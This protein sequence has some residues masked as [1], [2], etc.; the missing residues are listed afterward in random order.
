MFVYRAFS[1]LSPYKLVNV[2][3]IIDLVYC[4]VR[5][6][7]QN[8]VA[9]KQQSLCYALRVCRSRI[10][11][12]AGGVAGL[13]SLMFKASAGRAPELV[14]TRRLDWN[15]PRASSLT[16]LT[17]GASCWLGPQL[18]LS[19]G[20]LHAAFPCG[21]GYL[22]ARWLGS[23]SKSPKRPGRSCLALCSPA[24]KACSVASTIVTGPPGFK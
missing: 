1:C 19:T 2:P 7:P 18:G 17:G 13:C 23:K 9:K 6:H 15:P 21:L 8:I 3:K 16:R 11:T 10:R 4:S 20:H 22:T 14:A 5:S 24:L 12:E